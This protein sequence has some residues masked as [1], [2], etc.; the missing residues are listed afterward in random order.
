[1]K[2]FRPIVTA[3][4]LAVSLNAA[5]QS[6]KDTTLVIKESVI[7]D[8]R[9]SRIPKAGTGVIEIPEAMVKGTPALLG[10]P[11][12][13]KTLQLLPGVQSGTEGFSG[14]YIR[15]GSPDENLI[16]LDGIPLMSPG[17]MLGLFSVFQDEA[18]EKAILYKGSFPARYGG[19]VSGVIDVRSAEGNMKRIKGS[20][21]IGVLSDKFHIDGPVLKGRSAFSVSGRG[22]HTLLTDG[23]LKAVSFP[24]NYYFD[25]LDAKVTHRIGE[26]DL[27]TCGYFTGKDHLYYKEDGDRTDISWGN[28]AGYI[29]WKRITGNGL[30]C[31]FTAGT[32]DYAMDTGFL[33]RDSTSEK[34]RTG[35]KDLVVRTDVTVGHHDSHEFSSGAGITRHRFL[36]KGSGVEFSLY[37]EDEMDLRKSLKLNV[38]LRTST[39]ISSGKVFL[40][41]EPR[42]SFSWTPSGVM[43]MKVAYSRMSQYIHLLSPTLTTLPVDIWVPVTKKIRPVRTDQL[44]AGVVLEGKT[45]WSLSVEGY[46]KAMANVV[47]YNDGIVF[48]E[49]FDT[50][51]DQVSSGI[52][53]SAGLELL[54]RKHTGKT[55]GWIGY[56]LSRSERRFPDG[57]ISGGHWYPCRYDSRHAITAVLDHR[58]RDKWSATISWTYSSGGAMTLPSDDGSIP[59]RGNYRLPP[60]HR[61]DVGIRHAKGKGTWN[62]GI[63]NVYNRKNPNIVLYTSGEEDGPGSLKKVCILPIIPSVSYSRVF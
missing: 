9:T 37:A 19:R 5:A 11:D 4:L 34:Y 60:S 47:E 2:N 44:N 13:M 29:K 31:E 42:V 43:Q 55:T 16:L 18:V 32:S 35:M 25:D 28:K 49:D 56:T 52:G 3:F 39:F 53:R 41:P 7:S 50:W 15:G 24:A 26:R 48:I 57:S 33:S 6:K 22:M 20:I 8:I 63:Y 61:M 23:L 14:I 30:E 45:A 46:L 1:M 27:I 59:E 62:F 36:P 17:H 40:S 54:A 38:G 58:F 10:E 51:E 12:L 21:G